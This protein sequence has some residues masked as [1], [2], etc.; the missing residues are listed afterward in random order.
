MFSANA[1][2]DSGAIFIDIGGGTTDI[3]LVRQGGIEET[4][5]FARGGRSFTRRI[6]TSKGIAVEDAERLKLSYSDGKIKESDREEIQ[7]ILAP[8]CRAWMDTVRLRGE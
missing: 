7:A 2:A 5:M 4:R 3:A 1:S 8:E 6:A